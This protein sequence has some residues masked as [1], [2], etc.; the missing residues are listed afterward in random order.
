MRTEEQTEAERTFLMLY[1][2]WPA[3]HPT[4]TAAMKDMKWDTGDPL[5]DEEQKITGLLMSADDVAA[6]NEECVDEMFTIH[7]TDGGF[8]IDAQDASLLNLE[9][10]DYFEKFYLK[11]E[12]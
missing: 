5:I 3:N 4:V 7:P 11:E 12:D 2:G 10:D 1:T 8:L 6:H 9:W